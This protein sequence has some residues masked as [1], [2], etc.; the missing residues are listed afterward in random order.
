MLCIQYN[1]SIWGDEMKSRNICKF[2]N[3][4]GSDRLETYSFI[5]ETNEE[6]MRTAGTLEYNRVLLIKSGKGTVE[7]DGAKRT[8]TA[9][10]VIFAFKGEKLCIYPEEKC[11]YMYIDFGGLRADDLFLRFGISRFERLYSG[12]DGLIP[13]WYDSLMRASEVNLDLVSESILLYTFSRF[14]R[15]TDKKK[16]LIN[17]VLEMTEENF[18]DPATSLTSVAEVLSYNPKYISHIFK[19]EIGI[20]YAE[21]L[22]NVR[23]KYAVSLIECGVD[24]IKNVAYLSGFTDP[25]YFSTMFKKIVGVSPTEYANRKTQK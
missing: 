16:L 12:Y 2:I 18:T 19:K 23:I 3:E 8:F 4:T 9:G 13:L 5:C 6:V 17:E 15:T 7:I 22:R 25:L 10:T 14:V 24:S 21:Y 1:Q 11:E 20:G